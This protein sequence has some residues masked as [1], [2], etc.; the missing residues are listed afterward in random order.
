LGGK[1][2]IRKRIR[3]LEKIQEM[4]NSAI[5]YTTSAMANALDV[6]K[7]TISNYRKALRKEGLIGAQ[8]RV[9]IDGGDWMI[10]RDIFDEIPIIAKFASWCQ[11]DKLV[12]TEYTN[13]LYDIC[14]ATA[15]AP[16]KLITSLED[17]EILYDK[18][19][20]IWLKK[21]PNKMLDRYNRAIRKFLVFNQITLPPNSKV[22]PSG[23]ES[24]GE[25]SRVRL[26]DQQV[27]DGMDWFQKN[28]G[29]DWSTLFGI[30]HEIF[31]RPAT[32]LNWI[33]EFEIVHADVDGK[34]Y[35]YGTTEVFE[36]KTAKHFDKL[37]LNPIVLKRLSELPK[38]KPVIDG[39]KEQTSPIYAE[40]LREYYTDIGKLE[41]NTKYKKG[42]DGWLFFNRPIYSIRHSA[43]LM[44]M[45]RT[46]FNLELVAKMGWDDTK[47]LS[48]FYARTTVKN[49]MQAGTCYYCRPPI[50]TSDEKIFCSAS[51]ALAYLNGGRP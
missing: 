46:A 18:F 7:G 26:S 41:T 23:T 33:P 43:A 36:K 35:Q 19:T 38:N 37:I 27:E 51:H 16:D 32:M 42:V 50:E 47:T 45:R 20:Q 40:M 6:S 10:S 11:R 2:K 39:I 9:Q 1:L 4:E 29:D 25:Y 49:I 28:Y 44:W 3:T 48:K 17:A 22:M 15:T 12:P 14:R 21:Y 5:D 30:H 31:A 34:S 13:R 24:Q 8:K